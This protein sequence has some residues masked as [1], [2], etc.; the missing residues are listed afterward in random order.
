MKNPFYYYRLN[1]KYAI[2]DRRNPGEPIAVGVLY[3]YVHLLVNVLNAD[4]EARKVPTVRELLR[5]YE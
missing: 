5:A 4:T 3:T 2:E 1:G